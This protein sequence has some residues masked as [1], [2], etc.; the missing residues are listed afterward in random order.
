VRGAHPKDRILTSDL[1]VDGTGG[2]H[3]VVVVAGYDA[4]PGVEHNMG[5]TL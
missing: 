5:Q 3:S 4:L 2:A 1:E